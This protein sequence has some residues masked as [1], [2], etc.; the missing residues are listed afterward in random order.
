MI[1]F[2]GKIHFK[3]NLSKGSG[4]AILSLNNTGFS[5]FLSKEKE[6]NL[7]WMIYLQ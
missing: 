5:L 6:L 1:R 4:K 2:G 3:S 7:V